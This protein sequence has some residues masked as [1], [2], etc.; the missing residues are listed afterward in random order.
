MPLQFLSEFYQQL[1]NYI[2]I[3]NIQKYL[4]ESNNSLQFQKK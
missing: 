1:I 4:L 3:V 2:N